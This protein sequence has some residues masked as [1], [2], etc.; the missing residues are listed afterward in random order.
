MGRDALLR[1]RMG[2]DALLRVR[3]GRAGARPSQRDGVQVGRVRRPELEVWHL[4]RGA[5]VLEGRLHLALT[6]KNERRVKVAILEVDRLDLH[7]ARLVVARAHEQLTVVEDE[8][9]AVVEPAPEVEVVERLRK[10]L[11]TPVEAVVDGGD[12][13]V[14]ARRERTR[15]ELHTAVREVVDAD[16]ASV[17]PEL[18]IK[19]HAVD[20]EPRVVHALLECERA[21]IHRGAALHERFGHRVEASRHDHSSGRLERRPGGRRDGAP[22]VEA[23]LP[24]P[25]EIKRHGATYDTCSGRNNHLLHVHL[26]MSFQKLRRMT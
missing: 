7:R 3:Y 10:L 13:R 6:V 12:E 19:A 26:F 17:H 24:R 16:C 22:L 14:R 18:P 20:D 25:V 9:H 8:R 21:P 4:H 2:R 23:E 15:R 1:V 5:A 11:V